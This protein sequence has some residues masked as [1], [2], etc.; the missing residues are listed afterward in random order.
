MS[1]QL[2]VLMTNLGPKLDDSEMSQNGPGLC[3]D[4]AVKNNEEFE[5]QCWRSRTDLTLIKE[6]S[7]Q[8]SL[9]RV[10]PL[11]LVCISI[12]FCLIFGFYI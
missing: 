1:C 4:A 10:F 3:W 5:M 7:T 11:N 12:I 6:I 2:R 8:T 9:F